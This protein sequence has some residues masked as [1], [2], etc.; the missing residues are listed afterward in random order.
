MRDKTARIVLF[1][2]GVLAIVAGTFALFGL[3]RLETR[4]GSILVGIAAVAGGIN[5]VR[6]ARGP[7]PRIRPPTT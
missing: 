5:L 2:F 4:F 1:G 7:N 6:R 3:S